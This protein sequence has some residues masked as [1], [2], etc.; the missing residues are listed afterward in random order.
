LDDL[1]FDYWFSNCYHVKPLKLF[2]GMVV[3]HGFC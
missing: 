1:M 2:L 3:S